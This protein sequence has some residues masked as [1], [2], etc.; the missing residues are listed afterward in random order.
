[1][2]RLLRDYI[3]NI[4]GDDMTANFTR[5]VYFLTVCEYG[6]IAGAAEKLYITPQALNK[7]IRMLEAELGA[8]LFHH[9]TRRLNITDF[10]QFFRNQMQPVYQ[11][12]QNAMVQT[13]QYLN[14]AKPCLHVSFFQGIP[15]R[16]VIQ[17]L[18]SELLINLPDSQIE[19]GSAEMDQLI[20][21]LYG[22]KTDLAITYINPVEHLPNL[23]QIPLLTVKSSIVVAP[24]HPW[25]SKEFI[26]LED[27]S[28]EQVLFLERSHGP[29]RDGF[30]GNLKAA[31]Y[32]FAPDV[33]SMLAQLCLGRHYS[34]FPAA[35]RLIADSGLT[36]LPLPDGCSSD[37]RLVLLYR[38]DNQFASFFE[39]LKHIQPLFLCNAE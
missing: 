22:N 7:Q 38:P 27:M 30:Y 16:Q 18:I 11:F 15:K 29:D 1:M 17:P 5:I 2:P 4:K 28:K 25:A 35:H 34:V 33:N 6:S 13:E 12:Y 24:S 8:A 39:S 20:D 36:C 3:T 37:F 23:I 9:T 26:T 10:G 31:S 14:T 32:H 19:F 21:G